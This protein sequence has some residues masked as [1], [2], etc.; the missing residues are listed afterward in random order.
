[1]LIAVRSFFRELLSTL[2]NI[3]GLMVGLTCCLF[4]FLWVKDEL[5]YD[6]FHK[7]HERIFAVMENQA[8][9][10]GEI[11]TYDAS[12]APLAEKL[13]HDFP[14]VELSSHYSWPRQMLFSEGQQSIY[15][16]GFFADTSFFKLF[17]FPLIE[18]NPNKPMPDLKSVV[19]SRRMAEKYFPGQSALGKVLRIDN[20]WDATITAVIENVPENS[21][22]WFDFILP[23]QLYAQQTSKDLDWS[24][25]ITFTYVKL[26][27]EADVDSFSAKIKD[28]LVSTHVESSQIKLFLF[29]LNEW[30]LSGNLKMASKQVAD[31]SYM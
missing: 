3:A 5:R 31:E 8:Y 22:I 7:D 21:T 4:I 26:S 17:T 10:D 28:L 11:L 15:N 18:G 12:P 23:F 14:E 13:Q 20:E 29:P 25:H 2:I 1:M 16:E 6:L 24:N 19:I 27:A 9:S 30:R